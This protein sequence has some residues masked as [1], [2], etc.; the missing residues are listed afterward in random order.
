LKCVGCAS[1]KNEANIM[2]KNAIDVLM[3]GMSFWML[4]FGLSYGEDSIR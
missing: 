2:M 1:L 3:G 4:G